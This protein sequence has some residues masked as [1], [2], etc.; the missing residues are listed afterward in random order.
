M[1][2]RQKVL[3]FILIL[4]AS[5][6]AVLA[7]NSLIQPKVMATVALLQPAPTQPLGYYDYFGKLLSPQEANDFVR[8]QGLDPA[9]P[10]SYQRLGAVEIT[11]QL[12]E[13]GENIFFNTK[14]GDTF[15]LQG[16]FG[17]GAGLLR[18]QPELIAAIT[19][20]HGEP[21]TNLRLTLQEDLTLGSRTYPK[22]SVIDTGLDV[23][24]AANFPLGLQFDGSLTC[25]VCHVVL[26][27][28]GERLKGVPNG[29]LNIPLLVALSTNTAAGFARLDLNPLDPSYQGNG[30]TIIDSDNQLVTLPDPEK[31]ESAFDDAV[32]DV[33][34]GNFESSPD[35]IRNTNRLILNIS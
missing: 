34:F 5:F 24:R 35:A 32:L 22:G 20:L 9:D 29:D 8:N 17:F 3:M 21:T 16:V 2:W 33:P 18:V 1:R 10:V 26:S 19:E 30:K 23:E 4:T 12:L 15:G 13:S 28:T 7:S 11:Q 25:A 14:I 6:V 31:F 27:K